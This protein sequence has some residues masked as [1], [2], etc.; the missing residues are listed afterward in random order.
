MIDRANIENSP[1]WR[2]DPFTLCI[3]LLCLEPSSS[4]KA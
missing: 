1:A 4:E 3:S 2:D